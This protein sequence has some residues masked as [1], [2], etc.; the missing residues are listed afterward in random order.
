[1]SDVSKKYPPTSYPENRAALYS[2]QA[3]LLVASSGW[4]FFA[5]FGPVSLAPL[6][7]AFGLMILTLHKLDQ[8]Y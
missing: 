5:G 1:V 2:F 6:V 7:G 8:V 4:M 3:G